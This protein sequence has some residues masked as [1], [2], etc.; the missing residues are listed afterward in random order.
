[1]VSFFGQP[2]SD[3]IVALLTLALGL[4]SYFSVRLSSAATNLNETLI[5]RPALAL[6]KSKTAE[7]VF[8]FCRLFT[9]LLCV[10]AF[11]R[12]TMLCLPVR[13]LVVR[14]TE[15]LLLVLIA[16]SILFLRTVD[17]WLSEIR[18]QLTV[19]RAD[20]QE[21]RKSVRIWPN[22]RIVARVRLADNQLDFRVLNIS[23]VGTWCVT[24]GKATGVLDP[25][26]NDD[27][28]VSFE[29]E[30]AKFSRLFIPSK[31]TLGSSDIRARIRRTWM[32]PEAGCR[33]I[34]LEFL[35]DQ[36]GKWRAKLSGLGTH[37]D[38]LRS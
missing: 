37:S 5:N 31:R 34:A 14:G 28:S 29:Y 1:V 33:G 7:R 36:K 13:A 21:R 35:E 2:E 6:E 24:P 3:S 22:R 4:Y 30:V 25:K 10:L 11:A 19:P 12:L 32:Y 26:E 16:V 38:D 9:A 27:A 18:G 8:S 15:I 20:H 17:T 23:D